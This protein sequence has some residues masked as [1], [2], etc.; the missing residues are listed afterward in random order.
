M[1]NGKMQGEKEPGMKKNETEA[2]R[3]ERRYRKLSEKLAGTGPILQGTITERAIARENR[4]YGPYYQWTFKREG[5]T[6]TVNLSAGQAGLFQKALDNNREL[7]NTV[8]EMRELS[9]AICEAQTEG[10]K[11]RK[12]RKISGKGLS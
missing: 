5:K 10:V 8:K 11:K 7:E 9:L 4:T 3:L 2:Q 6:V 1:G 12:P